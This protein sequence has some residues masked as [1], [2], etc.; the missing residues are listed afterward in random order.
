MPPAHRAC[1]DGRNIRTWGYRGLAATPIAPAPTRSRQVMTRCAAITR[2]SYRP[3]SLLR[4]S[5]RKS[6]AFHQDL[7]QRHGQDEGLRGAE[8]VFGDAI[9][10]LPT[11]SGG[12]L[13]CSL[14]RIN[15]SEDA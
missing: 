9:K 11:N 3:H 1:G 13:A 6:S 8:I 5:L 10:G 14:K 7:R 12:V 4:P 15:R 2:L